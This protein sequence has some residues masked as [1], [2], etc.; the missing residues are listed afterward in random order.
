M[1]KYSN[2]FNSIIFRFLFIFFSSVA[3]VKA[4]CKTVSIFLL[5]IL[6]SKLLMIIFTLFIIVHL[7]ISSV[8]LTSLSTSGLLLLISS[9]V[10]LSTYWSQNIRMILLVLFI[11]LILIFIN[12]FALNLLNDLLIWSA[13]LHSHLGKTA[14]RSLRPTFMLLINWLMLLLKSHLSILSNSWLWFHSTD[15]S[16]FLWRSLSYVLLS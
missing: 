4:T 14:K 10:T 12:V 1:I 2:L 7:L 13:I 11:L 5:M 9:R 6:H 16:V 15:W 3:D 8:W